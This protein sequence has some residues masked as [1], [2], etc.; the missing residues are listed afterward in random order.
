MDW[1]TALWDQ[2]DVIEKHTQSGL[3]LIDRYVKFVRER[4]D[5]EQNYAKQLKALCKKYSRRGSKEDQEMKFSNQQV[6]QELLCELN[7]CATLRENMAE[8]MNLNI[9]VELTKYLH[10]LKLE[11]KSYLNEVKKIQ[12]N[13][14]TS[15]KQL[16][17]SKKRFEKEWKEAEK[18][19]QQAEKTEQDPASNKQD[20]DKAR[21]H[22][23]QRLDISD[24]CKNE[25][26]VQLQKY[27]K[28]QN[29]VYHTEIP[30]ILNKL[31]Q[32]EEGRIR[33]LAE[34][35][36]V[37]ANTERTM[38]PS[39]SQN[40][41][42]ISVQGSSTYET[43]DSL[44][45]IEQYK[46]GLLPP[47]DV[48]FEDYS[49]GIRPA[50]VDNTHHVPKVRIKQ[51][52]KKSKGGPVDRNMPPPLEDF[53]HLPSDQRK[54]RLQEK[55]DEL[56]KE[57]Q[58]ETDQSEGLNKMRRVYEQNNQLGDPASLEPQI[59]QTTHNINRLMGD[60][61]RYQAWLGEAG[62]VP[63]YSNTQTS[64]TIQSPPNPM[65]NQFHSSF[66]E[67]FDEDVPIAQCLALYDFNGVKA[68]EVSMQVG[69]RLSV[70]DDDMGDGWV[71]VKK[72]NGKIGYV[73]ASY[74]QIN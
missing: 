55:I 32:M 23:R 36:G 14:D 60:L 24:E 39:I 53:S 41:E 62:G 69:E 44:T 64:P 68:G 70:L 20:V 45:L 63:T 29:Q 50:V 30:N 33:K 5:I 10:E 18:A 8:N 51:L 66:D 35:Y 19:N 13:L 40:L 22:A 4:V 59:N 28:E 43:Q 16:E 48:E 38:L 49:L 25:Y 31:Q 26:A 61:S 37:L 3:D 11:R 71:R 34:G 17:N 9:C 57:L 67:D 74:I 7:E 1:G 65:N 47:S 73:P 58:K 46:S 15:Y 6:F 52:F 54:K 12:Q 21:I 56:S 27:N 42:K 2:H 72:T